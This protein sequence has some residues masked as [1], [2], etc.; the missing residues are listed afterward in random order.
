MV[1]YARQEYRQ[2]QT[3][4]PENS[5]WGVVDVGGLTIE[6]ARQRVLAVYLAPFELRYEDQVIQVSAET[7][8]FRV[9]FIESGQLYSNF[10]SSFWAYLWG[11]L[12]SPVEWKVGF[13]LDKAQLKTYLQSEIASRYDVNPIPPLPMPASSRF[14]SGISGKALDID[15]SLIR[16]EE[17]L[18]NPLNRQIELVVREQ[19]ARIT[20]ANLLKAILINELRVA[21]YNG[22]AEIFA[23]HLSENQS[24]HFAV[25]NGEEVPAEIAFSAASTIKIPI[26]LTALMQ[27][28][29]PFP[30]E[31]VQL[32]ERMMVYSENPPADRIMESYIG[33]TLAPLK[34]TEMLQEAGFQNTFLAGY[35]YLG[36]PLLRRFDTPANQRGDI[37]LNPDVYNQTTAGEMGQL[38][39]AIYQCADSGSGLLIE[40]FA[41]KVTPEK[42]AFLLEMMKRNRIGVLGQAGLPEGLPFAHKHGWSE[43]SDGYLHTIS[44]VGIVF[45]PQADYVLVIFL[46]DPVQLLFDPANALMARLSQRIYN[47]WNPDHQI[48]WLFGDV[49]YR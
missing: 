11:R 44:D 39:R 28:E 37:N 46:Y 23:F 43:E 48:E 9:D 35:F 49:L 17:V 8:G 20:D 4:L 26:L 1:F 6:E 18:N 12:Q 36:A 41:G 45:G 33:S 40:R 19:P 31:F 42:C 47:A 21:K 16:F 10:N 2:V 3:V 29:A 5:R 7:L 22:I 13:N 27:I 24:L 25:E 15:A 14:A 34:V 38:L 30:D 32:A